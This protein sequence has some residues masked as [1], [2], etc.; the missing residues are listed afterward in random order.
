VRYPSC[1]LVI[2]VVMHYRTR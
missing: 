1:I 2:V